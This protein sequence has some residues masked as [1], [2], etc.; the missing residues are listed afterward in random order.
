MS[1]LVLLA[2]AY[3]VDSVCLRFRDPRFGTVEVRRYY[4]VHLKNQKIE[5]LP[6]ET[7]TETCVHSLFPHLDHNPCW[8]VMRHREQR[9]EINSGASAVAPSLKRSSH[10]YRTGGIGEAESSAR[11]RRI[12]TGKT[13]GYSLLLNIS[14]TAF[15][16]P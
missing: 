15:Q 1:G 11:A 8:Y 7:D 4:A 9:I 5:Y 12:R 2:I 6:D 3:G 13:E 10:A 16:S 14:T